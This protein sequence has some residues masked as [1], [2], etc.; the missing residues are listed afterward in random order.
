MELCGICE[1]DIG[2][3]SSLCVAFKS[4]SRCQAAQL[5]GAKQ[6]EA[7]AAL[8]AVA[9]GQPAQEMPPA[10]PTSE[11]PAKPAVKEVVEEKRPAPA[12]ETTNKS[13]SDGP[14]GQMKQQQPPV[15]STLLKQGLLYARST[16][17]TETPKHCPSSHDLGTLLS[18]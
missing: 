11:A 18:V 4:S 6:A 3:S 15:S 16:T 9:K 17:E 12:T 7:L 5:A 8:Q 13:A 14:T 1:G 2:C 10:A